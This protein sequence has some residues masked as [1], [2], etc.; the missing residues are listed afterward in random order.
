[1]SVAGISAV[2]SFAVYGPTG[3]ED[4]S[5]SVHR[6]DVSAFV[7]SLVA[8]YGKPIEVKTDTVQNGFGA[9]F[10]RE[11][12][13]WRFS[14]GEAEFVAPGSKLDQADFFFSVPIPAQK[15]KVDF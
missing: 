4:F 6:N 1:M 14:D 8:K 11:T 9:R 5:L 7:A 15:P 13:K 2:D 10:D 3:L 12:L